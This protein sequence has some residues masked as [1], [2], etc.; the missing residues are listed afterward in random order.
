MFSTFIFIKGPYYFFFC[1]YNLISQTGC[2]EYSHF[3]TSC[4]SFL[5]WYKRMPSE[6]MP[7]GRTYNRMFS[8][9]YNWPFEATWKRKPTKTLTSSRIGRKRTWGLWIPISVKVNPSLI[10]PC[11]Y[12]HYF[13]FL[14]WSCDIINICYWNIL[15]R[16]M[17]WYFHFT[18]GRGCELS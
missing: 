6:K 16:S 11:V 12:V 18:K 8:Q 13:C 17:E 14:W 5:T 2:F 7:S 15:V 4:D 1:T 3:T 10:M 9:I